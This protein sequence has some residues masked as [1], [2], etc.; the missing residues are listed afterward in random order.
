MHPSKSSSKHTRL[1][2]KRSPQK[3]NRFNKA[4]KDHQGAGIPIGNQPNKGAFQGWQQHIMNQH[5]TPHQDT[6]AVFWH[7]EDLCSVRRGE[8]L[9]QDRQAR[10][11]DSNSDDSSMDVWKDIPSAVL[12]DGNSILLSPPKSQ[13]S[14]D[15][16]VNFSMTNP[17]SI[18]HQTT[19]GYVNDGA[20]Y[21]SK[22]LSDDDKI[23]S[24]DKESNRIMAPSVHLEPKD[25]DPKDWTTV[26]PSKKF[27]HSMEN[28]VI[29]SG[30]SKYTKKQ[31]RMHTKKKEEAKIIKSLEKFNAL[32]AASNKLDSERRARSVDG[33][34][35]KKSKKQSTTRSKSMD[36]NSTKVK[37]YKPTTLYGK[38]SNNTRPKS[39]RTSKVSPQNITPQLKAK[40]VTPQ[41]EIPSLRPTLKRKAIDK[42]VSQGSPLGPIDGMKNRELQDTSS[43]VILDSDEES[44]DKYIQAHKKGNKIRENEDSEMEQSNSSDKSQTLDSSQNRPE[45]MFEPIVV[46][47]D[48][49]I[50]SPIIRSNRFTPIP[51]T[52]DDLNT[53]ASGTT[54]R[55]GQGPDEDVEQPPECLRY[56]FHVPLLSASSQLLEEE[57]QKDNDNDNPLDTFSIIRQAA[58]D[59]ITTMLQLD[60]HAMIISWATENTFSVIRSVA[61]IPTTPAAFALYFHNYKPKQSTGTM[62]LRVKVHTQFHNPKKFEEQLGY[63]AKSSAMK[64]E[65]CDM[66]CEN[67]VGIGYIMFST[68]S[69]NFSALLTHLMTITGY[70]WGSRLTAL[71]PRDKDEEWKNR[72]KIIQLLVPGEYEESAAYEVNFAIEKVYSLKLYKS[73]TARYKFLY[74]EGEMANKASKINHQTFCNWHKTHCNKICFKVSH[75]IDGDLDFKYPMKQQQYLTIRQVV[76]SIQCR[77]KESPFFKDFLFHDVE[78]SEDLSKTWLGNR[79]GPKSSGFLFSYYDDNEAEA[80]RMIRGLGVYTEA[81]FGQF[82]LPT[83]A[84]ETN[85]IT[86]MFTSEHWRAISRWT[87]LVEEGRFETPLDTDMMDRFADDKDKPFALFAALEAEE[88]E[89]SAVLTSTR[90]PDTSLPIVNESNTPTKMLSKADQ[91]ERQMILQMRHQDIGCVDDS[92]GGKTDPKLV[93]HVEVRSVQST[94][95][96]LTNGTTQ[97]LF[98]DTSNSINSNHTDSTPHSSNK[99]LASLKD[100][101]AEACLALVQNVDSEEEMKKIIQSMM[102]HKLK[103][104]IVSTSSRVDQVMQ[105]V[106]KAKKLK[107]SLPSDQPALLPTVTPQRSTGFQSSSHFSAGHKS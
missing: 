22:D 31:M 85:C 87:W 45:T 61:T 63:W 42:G 17:S 105:E 107:S 25:L 62:Y 73:F 38:I 100:V 54:T 40:K 65:I 48:A 2:S 35:D 27:D 59:L 30:L 5:A 94:T 92:N 11:K 43:Q 56:K 53:V 84:G 83:V 82:A 20:S 51:T 104:L 91:K 75:I 39:P 60:P 95:S 93:E 24:F 9:Q 12:S 49:A 96:S 74:P 106:I 32:Q 86:D 76:L 34:S 19:I 41:Q 3:D 44:L 99:S 88:T 46:D 80:V 16:S 26:S 90:S 1:S 101:N 102:D 18:Q 68:Q 36:K 14:T 37:H 13:R 69:S 72:V 67:P 4:R 71:S 10:R 98:K 66:Q 77:N 28:I 47:D 70:E 33:K 6:D 7:D 97:S 50:N 8:Q 81:T 79:L 15:S 64:F 29:P 57:F 103:Q 89:Q 23:P 21:T 52:E 78:F 55:P 58:I